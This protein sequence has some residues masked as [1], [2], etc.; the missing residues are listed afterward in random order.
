MKLPKLTRNQWVLV[1]LLLVLTWQ[2]VSFFWSRWGLITVHSKGQPLS[3]V[4]RQIEKQG[5]VTIKTNMDPN[6]AVEMWVDKVSLGE[7]LETLSVVTDS[8][9]RLAYYVAPD[10]SAVATALANF[11]AGQKNE[12]WHSLFVPLPGFGTDQETVVDPR[13]DTWVVKTISDS[14]LQGYLKE[15]AKNVSATFYVPENFNP[16]VKGPPK[17]GAISSAL[18]KLASSA[19]AKYEEVF[20]LQGSERRA[21][22]GEGERRDDGEPRFAGNFGDG[23]RGRGG[24]DRDAME[25]R[26][27]NEIN[28]LPPAERTAA[29]AEHDQRKRFFDSLKDMTPEQRA[30]AIQQM[31]TDPTI[32]DKMDSANNNRDSRRT[33]QQRIQRAG[34]YLSRMAAAKGL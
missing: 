18:P 2:V 14:T 7:A 3:Q 28:K 5:H 27:Q 6:K 15:A 29:Q 4:I 34:A 11:T 12:G 32:Q 25:E 30:A 19:N 24:F 33:P 21:D 17:S 10:K 8:R 23:G 9:W 22:R 16:T 13:K 20:L 26:I 1:V 31:M